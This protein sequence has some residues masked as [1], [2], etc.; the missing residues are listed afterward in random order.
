MDIR[1]ENKPNTNKTKTLFSKS[2]LKVFVYRDIQRYYETFS[3]WVLLILIINVNIT[4][5]K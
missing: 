5:N 1:P 2:I 4:Q 3:D